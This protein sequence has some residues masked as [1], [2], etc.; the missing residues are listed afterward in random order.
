[1]NKSKVTTDDKAQYSLFE[2]KMIDGK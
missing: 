2:K 1:M